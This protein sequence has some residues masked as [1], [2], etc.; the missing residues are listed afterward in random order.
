MWSKVHQLT[1]RS[2]S[3]NAASQYSA[4][5]ADVLNSHYA[6]ISANL[7]KNY[8]QQCQQSR[9]VMALS[10]K[11]E[12]IQGGGAVISPSAGTRQHKTLTQGI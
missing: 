11:P 9:Y 12:H 10:I 3:V 2:K 1:G 5:T 6:A 7:Q 8:I 4:I